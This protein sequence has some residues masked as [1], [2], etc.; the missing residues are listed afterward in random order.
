M[1]TR[2]R[3]LAPLVLVLAA[4]ACG[5]QPTAISIPN[6]QDG[7]LVSQ[8]PTTTTEP[9][10]PTT[11]DKPVPAATTAPKL[12]TGGK[13]LP[14]A[15]DVP[16]IG[17]HAT[18][19]MAL[20]LNKDGSVSTPPVDQPQRVGYYARSNAPCRP[21]PMQ[22]PFV[23]LAHI[24]GAGK[25][26]AFSKLSTLKPGATVTV[27]LDNGAHCTYRITQLAQ[28]KKTDDK[29]LAARIW[30]AVPNAQIRLVSCGGAFIGGKYGYA[31]NL[32]GI[33]ELV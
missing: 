12:P 19:L 26:G 24:D 6:P 8:A 9:P 1:S 30:G 10:A 28:L 29:A 23:V 11:T 31:D 32:I 13:G 4:V 33:G 14:A 5:P 16:S 2:V 18:N 27:G 15:V 7:P 20:G 22:V 3:L 21:G 25:P 17:V